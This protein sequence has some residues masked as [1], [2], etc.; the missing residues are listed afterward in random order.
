MRE[1]IYNRSLEA[2]FLMN[3]E[4]WSRN[5]SQD[6]S[7]ISFLI[8]FEAWARNRSREASGNL[9]ELV[10][11]LGQD[12]ALGKQLEVRFL[13]D[14]EAWARNRSHFVSLGYSV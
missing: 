5:R 4:A 7:G 6:A 14:F 12:I 13:I 3:F 8:D 9:F 1:I 10:L 2:H 11:R